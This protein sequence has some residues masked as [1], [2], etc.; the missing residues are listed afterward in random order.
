MKTEQPLNQLRLTIDSDLKDVF[1]VGLT[2]NKICEHMQ[3]GTI[4]SSEVEL[5]AVEGVTNAILHAYRKHT[6]NEVS[7]TLLIR[8]NRLEI[9]I[10]DKGEAM[11]PAQQSRLNWGS[12]AL[13]FDPNERAALPEGGM[14]LQIMH[15]FMDE[16]SYRS[17]GEVNSL[18]LIR[19]LRRAE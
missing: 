17:E 11:T 16:V 15:E 7:V 8:H 4:E 13:D 6:G 3:M 9:E 5:C 12:D 14:G 2:V 10:S 19:L 1:L 18:K